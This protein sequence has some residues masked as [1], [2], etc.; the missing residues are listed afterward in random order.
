MKVIISEK[1]IVSIEEFM[2]NYLGKQYDGNSKLTHNEMLMFLYEKG[3]IIPEQVNFKKIT[4]EKLLTGDYIAVKDE[5]SRI[6]FYQNPIKTSLKG[7][8]IEL[9]SKANLEKTKNARRQNINEQGYVE[10]INGIVKKEDL[11]D[12]YT[13]IET[14]RQRQ[15]VKGYKKRHY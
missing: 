10:A 8:L 6:L 9:Q 7:L 11:T 15:F 13:Y 4:N 14:N 1:Q 3:S 5:A 12:E 2:T